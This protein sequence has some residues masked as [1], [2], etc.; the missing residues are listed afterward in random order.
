[1]TRDDFLS[2]AEYQPVRRE[3]RQRLS[4]LKRRRQVEIGPLAIFHFENIAT[5][6]HQIQEML[7]IEKGG[8]AQL[9]EELEAYAPLIPQGAELVATVM[10]EI[11]D[12]ARRAA[13]LVRLGGIEN[14]AYIDVDGNRV[15]SEPDPTRE[16]TSAEGKASSVQFLKF[17]FAPELISRF[18]MPGARIV[19]GFD[20]PN[21]THMV[22]LP[23]LVRAALAQDFD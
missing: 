17:T 10:L 15:R 9:E 12:P 19:V 11:E 7:Y 20:H 16:N 4:E 22:T 6:R 18:K 3:R 1:M 21:Y 14:H 5:V 2:P 23:D 13:E 8:D